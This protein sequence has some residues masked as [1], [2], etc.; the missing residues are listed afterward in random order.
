M[1]QTLPNK[2]I[3]I[4]YSRDQKEI[5]LSLQRLIE[6]Y[7]FPKK[8]ITDLRNLPPHDTHLRPV[9][10][11]IEDLPVNT[12][13]YKKSLENE[14][15]AARF[16]LVLCSKSSA[17]QKSVCHWEIS[18]FLKYHSENDILPIVLDGF[19]PGSDGVE[20]IPEELKPI[21]A[22]RNVPR[23][24]RTQ[25]VNS[26]ANRRTFFQIIGFLININTSIL[27]NRYALQK[28]KQLIKFCCLI[29]CILLALIGL[30]FYGLFKAVEAA[31]NAKEARINAER[32]AI[33]EKQRL[34]FERQVFPYSIV[35][36]YYNNFILKLGRHIT[37][38][39][40]N[41]DIDN[42]SPTAPKAYL[43]I[44]LPNENRTD[45]YDL[46]SE[47]DEERLETVLTPL[48]NDGKWEKRTVTY[49]SPNESRATDATRII[50][51]EEIENTLFFIDGASTIHSIKKVVDL[52][53]KEKNDFYNCSHVNML[54]RSYLSEFKKC[55]E[56]ECLQD[57]Q[58]SNKGV[59]C[60]I[61]IIFIDNE[62]DIR[63]FYHLLL[64]EQNNKK[65]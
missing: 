15:Q 11:D 55:L 6:S 27:H 14:L 40:T 28:R 31:K 56:R 23:W 16:L 7:R 49:Q 12:D 65:K 53:T 59:E 33:T 10:V 21:I 62:Q 45:A 60:A 29:I 48:C 20:V 38:A 4:S 17:R 3:F 13:E 39:P 1:S 58:V 43:F 24:E 26:R 18:T 44:K 54:T 47:K 61:E 19:S 9:F 64:E 37:S 57:K 8:L 41:M 36:S 2:Y 51:P 34:N 35:T 50:P 5:A 63:D 52:L 25:K 22:K 32:L 30:L 46:L 42:P